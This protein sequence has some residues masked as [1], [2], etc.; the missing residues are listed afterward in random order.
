M[1]G[2]G[3]VLAAVFSTWACGSPGDDCL[4]PEAHCDGNIASNCT[5]RE[6]VATSYQAWKTTSCGAGTCQVD[7][8]GAFC[9]LTSAPDPRCDAANTPFC[10]GALVTGC[11]A[12]YAI[13][14]D[15]CG[16]RT[17]DPFCVD[18]SA[19]S[20]FNRHGGVSGGTAFCAAEAEANPICQAAFQNERDPV[21]TCDGNDQLQCWYGYLLK[22]TPLA[23]CSAR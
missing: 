16:S 22:R 7:G 10:A 21:L 6:D 12:G 23:S 9:A 13:S 1:R 19:K 5:Y 18:A 3:V 2:L 15:D 17:N 11:R 20:V 14:T 8:Q 4:V